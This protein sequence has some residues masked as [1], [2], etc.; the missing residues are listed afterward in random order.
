MTTALPDGSLLLHIGPQ[1]TGSTAIQAAMHHA[2]PELAELGVLYPGTTPCPHEAGWSVMGFGSPVGHAPPRPE[3]WTALIEEIAAS[4]L[5]RVC[6]SNEDLARAD[7]AAVARI[8][9]GLGAD[10]THL[11]FVARRLDKLLPSYWQQRLKARM[12]LSYDEFLHFLLDEPKTDWEYRLAWEPHDVG[13]IVQRWGRHLPPER[14]TVIVADES[15]RSQLPTVFGQLL[16]VPVALLD[17]PEAESNLSMTF[18]ETEV[19]R[20]LNRL[21]A[22]AGWSPQQYWRLIQTGAIKALPNTRRPGDPAIRGLPSW[23]YDKVAERA[24]AQADAITASGCH[25][26]GDPSSLLLPGTVEPADLP[27]PVDAISLDLM[28]DVVRGVVAGA[29]RLHRAELKKAKRQRDRARSRTVDQLSGRDLVKVLGG[30]V[31][32]RLRLR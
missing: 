1:K 31:A 20:R 30:R 16:G 18:T 28:A 6:L 8:L 5:P 4:T 26:I 7:D 19:V 22:D 14:I 23:A 11:V 27:E 12:T 17:P 15:D 3:T 21:Y 25:V 9:D 2:R 29:D 10:R 32:K 13:A 24:Q